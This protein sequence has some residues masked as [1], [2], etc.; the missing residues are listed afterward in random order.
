M[1]GCT[2]PNACT[3][4]HEKSYEQ[5]LTAMPR[6]Y[7]HGSDELDWRKAADTYIRQRDE[8]LNA[9]REAQAEL[10]RLKAEM[11]TLHEELIDDNRRLATFLDGVRRALEN[12]VH[13]LDFGASDTVILGVLCDGL[14]V[15]LRPSPAKAGR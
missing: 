9:V 7:D 2:C 8:A 13:Q 5:P 3:A 6:D 14:I 15:A 11:A 12:S 1:T 4:C 10:T